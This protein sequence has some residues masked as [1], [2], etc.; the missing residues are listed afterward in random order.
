MLLLVIIQQNNKYITM[1]TLDE[2]NQLIKSRKLTKLDEI[3]INL[4]EKMRDH[5]YQALNYHSYQEKINVNP[6]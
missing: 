2:I 6:G 1:V 4:N 5:I 3:F